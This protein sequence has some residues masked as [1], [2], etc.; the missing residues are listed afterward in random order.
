VIKIGDFTWASLRADSNRFLPRKCNQ[1]GNHG[2][3]VAAT[4]LAELNPYVSNVAAVAVKEDDRG[5]CR[6]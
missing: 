4:E 3:A 1:R 5:G 2:K 6:L